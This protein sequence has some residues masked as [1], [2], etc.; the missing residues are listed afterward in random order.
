LPA[1]KMAAL[2]PESEILIIKERIKELNGNGSEYFT[3]SNYFYQPSWRSEEGG[4]GQHPV[5]R[6]QQQKRPR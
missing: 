5:I 4:G 3:S 2:T 1:A 6:A